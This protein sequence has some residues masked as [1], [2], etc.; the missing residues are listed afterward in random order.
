[1]NERKP[2]API[3]TETATQLETLVDSPGD[4]TGTAP[5]TAGALDLGHFK[6]IRELGRGGMGRVFLARQLEPVERDVALKLIRNRVVNRSTLARFEVERQILAQMQHPA[7]AQVHDAGTTP[8]GYPYFAMEYVDGEPLD[9]FMARN[10]LSLDDRL[11]LFLRVCQGV[12]HAHQ[13]G[14]VHR[15]LKPAN[16]LVTL[17]DGV[18]QPKIIDFGI[19]TAS[20]READDGERTRD[21]VGT[22]EYMA[23]EQFADGDGLIDPRSDV[24]SLGVILYE[25]LVDRPPVEPDRL[26]TTT[27][28]RPTW[29]EATGGGPPP[30]PSTRLSLASDEREAIARRR[31]T[32][33]RSLLRSLRGDLDAIV[34]KALQADRAGRYDS[35]AAMADDIE[36][37][38]ACRPV[39]ARA[40]TRPYVLGK[41]MRRHAIAIGSASAVLLALLAG[42]AAATLGM[43]EAQRQFERAEARQRDLEQVS[44][45]QQSMLEDIDA[46]AMGAGIVETMRKQ[47]L[48][49]LEDE[50]P[51]G[52]DP[53]VFDQVASRTNATDMAREVIDRHMLDRARS[54]IESEFADQPLLQADLYDALFQVYRGV[55]LERPLPEVAERI[56]S[57][58]Q[59]ALDD[60]DLDV[61]RG[62]YRLGQAHF[63]VADY[64]AAREQ[65]ETTIAALD[66]ERLDEAAFELRLHARN[67]LALTHVEAGERE[68]AVSLARENIEQA[69]SRS[70]VEEKTRFELH[71]TLGYVLARSGRIAEALR[72]FRHQADGLGELLA[73]DDPALASAM[74]N[75]GAALAALE[76]HE[77]AL[78]INREALAIL[79]RAKGRRHP[80]TLRLTSNLANILGHLDRGDEAVELLEDNVERRREV[81]G[82]DHPLT[83]R[84]MLN[85]GS[86][87]N[88]VGRGEE[89][90]ALLET[91]VERRRALLGDE[92]LDTL[93]A[94]EVRA[95]IL[96]DL[97]RFDESAEVA[98]DVHRLRSERLG[99]DHRRTLTAGW[100]L[101]QARLGSGDAAGAVE[102]IRRAL[103]ESRE[104]RGSEHPATL[105]MAIHLIDALRRL[106][107]DDEAEGV[108]RDY[109]A[110]LAGRPADELDERQRELLEELRAIRSARS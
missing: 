38:L 74:I 110:E 30:A 70:S 36:R 75:V 8:Q 3:D 9:R 45:F 93:M 61:L 72:E 27:G 24:Y 64:A 40:A 86:A 44:S 49:S 106:E 60:N 12:Q 103:A 69:R 21:V 34:L 51:G 97:G 55:G 58:R 16:I 63:A 59:Q 83:L 10:R 91:V 68:A 79:E 31:D 1:M 109:L 54:S 4:D 77:E 20:R 102:P 7:I 18:G 26:R 90:L 62:R 87:Y 73:D 89:A 41:F 53:A 43:L 101:G 92:H 76:R 100:L 78:E 57:L 50:G 94:E 22:P 28:S 95:S 23:P 56:L 32:R 14:I 52:L 46:R 47:F 66:D 65:L 2:D 80:E 105:T 17:I 6:L 13:R 39:S 42:L 67:R 96:N 5:E 81:M 85:L 19:A 71:G 48:A 11:E 104:R 37:Y 84:A 25:L 82:A 99:A 88:R 35:P 15:D 107:R 29:A 108:F 33:Y 98:A